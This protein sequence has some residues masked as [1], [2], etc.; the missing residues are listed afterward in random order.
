MLGLLWACAV[1]TEGSDGAV[2]EG[3]IVGVEDV[4]E[5][6]VVGMAGVDDEEGDEASAVY[7]PFLDC[8]EL[9]AGHLTG[10]PA[11]KA[12]ETTSIDGEQKQSWHTDLRSS[13]WLTVSFK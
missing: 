3:E 10:I 4:E 7:T 6:G 5:D 2:E 8:V 1:C 12:G 11:C 13:Q 9:V